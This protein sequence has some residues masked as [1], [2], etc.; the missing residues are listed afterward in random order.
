[1]SIKSSGKNA[2]AMQN[3]YIA[4]KYDRINLTIQKGE[5]EVIKAHADSM[6][7]SVNAFITRAISNQMEADREQN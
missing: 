4:E 2:T 7:E 5:K 6:G 1:M 3:K